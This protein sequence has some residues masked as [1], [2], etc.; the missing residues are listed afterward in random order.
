MVITK[1]TG[2]RRHT[3]LSDLR[4]CLSLCM[5]AIRDLDL[6]FNLKHARDGQLGDKN[7]NTK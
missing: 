7:Y 5:I 3:G 2:S 6:S 4:F 1:A